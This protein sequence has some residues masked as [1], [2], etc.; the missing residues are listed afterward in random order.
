MK[1]HCHQEEIN[2]LLH[3]PCPH[4]NQYPVQIKLDLLGT[5]QVGFLFPANPRHDWR[6]SLHHT[7]RVTICF[8]LV[9]VCLPAHTWWD[10][11]TTSAVFLP[12]HLVCNRVS[13]LFTATQASLAGLSASQGV[14]SFYLPSCLMRVGPHTSMLGF[15]LVLRI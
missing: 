12:F 14:S 2:H 11:R 15:T 9:C 7:C 6:S 8:P 10:W 3:P 1:M 4:S 5:A 13:L